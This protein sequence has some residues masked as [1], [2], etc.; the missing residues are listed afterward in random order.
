[1]KRLLKTSFFV[2]AIA[3]LASLMSSCTQNDGRIG[4]LFGTW[5]LDSVE[6]LADSQTLT[7]PN[8]LTFSFQSSVVCMKELLPYHDRQEYWGS[9][10]RDGGELTLNYDNHDD[11]TDTATPPY[12]LPEG[13]GFD[14]FSPL[15]HFSIVELSGSRMT[16]DYVNSYGSTLRYSFTKIH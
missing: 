11:L 16:L 2:L 13:Y 14:T 15:L 10:V 12:T 6:S 8:P 4:D 3:M 9:W 1:M 7:L 5:R